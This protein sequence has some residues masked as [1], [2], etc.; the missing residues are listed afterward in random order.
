MIL[1]YYPVSRMST[2]FAPKKCVFFVKESGG[3]VQSAASHHKNA[4]EQALV[5]SIVPAYKLVGKRT[6]RKVETPPA[7][8]K[9]PVE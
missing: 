7:R 2:T 1:I 4:A 6:F 9:E 5:S 8:K 3:L